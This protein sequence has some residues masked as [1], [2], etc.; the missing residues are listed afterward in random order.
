M[1]DRTLEERLG[2]G[3][4][5]SAARNGLT[6][7]HHRRVKDLVEREGGRNWSPFSYIK[8]TRA[9]IYHAYGNNG[10]DNGYRDMPE[11]LSRNDLWT[12]RRKKEPKVL[13]RHEIKDHM[14]CKKCKKVRLWRLMNRLYNKQT[15][16]LASFH[17]SK[18]NGNLI[19]NHDDEFKSWSDME[20]FLSWVWDDYSHAYYVSVIVEGSDILLVSAHGLTDPQI[21]AMNGYQVFDKAL[22]DEDD[23]LAVTV[24]EFLDEFEFAKYGRRYKT[25]GRRINL[26]GKTSI[27]FMARRQLI[28][29]FACAWLALDKPKGINLVFNK[30]R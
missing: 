25:V 15:V 19:F 3:N 4:F 24:T 5:R 2:R 17:R 21:L 14:I 18:Y 1:L 27:E 16:R 9:P 12:R 7:P 8:S 28:V 29:C 13:L 30:K 10:M 11:C 6:E 20:T 23:S 22:Y 26:A